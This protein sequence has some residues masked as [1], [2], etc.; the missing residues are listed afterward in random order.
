MQR[1]QDF[2]PPHYL[3]YLRLLVESVVL[4]L[5]ARRP[6]RCSCILLTDLAVP[7]MIGSQAHRALVDGAMVAD[8]VLFLLDV[9]LGPLGGCRELTKR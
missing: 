6:D 8:V 3:S 4:R 1:R 5:E 2:L 9:L 7:P